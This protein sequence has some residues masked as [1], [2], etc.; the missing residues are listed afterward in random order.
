VPDFAI[1]NTSEV[2]LRID[3]AGANYVVGS[4]SVFYTNNVDISSN[5]YAASFPIPAGD[6][7]GGNWIHLAGTYDGAKWALYRNGL[8]VASAA[9]AVGALPVD[10]AD[11]AIGATAEGWADNFAG[12]VDEVAIYGKALTPQ[13]IATHYVIGRAGTTTLSIAH[14]GANVTIAWPNGTT[15]Q[16]SAT[17]SGGYADV[18]GTPT[19]PL[20][21]PATGTKYY[22]WRL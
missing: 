22:R 12:A 14:S 4:T 16:Q 21:I 13:Q 6:L 1:T 8:Q 2:F 19:S 5:T 17:V 3:G 11:W 18:P 20:T 9:S 10:N 15:L 7:G